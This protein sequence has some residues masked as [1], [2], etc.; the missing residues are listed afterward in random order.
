MELI[1]VKYMQLQ[2]VNHNPKKLDIWNFADPYSPQYWLNVWWEKPMFVI[3]ADK[4]I[5]C[6]LC[7]RNCPTGAITGVKTNPYV[8]DQSKCIRCGVCISKCKFQAIEKVYD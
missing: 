6:S 8:L 1:N 4:C 2:N 3:N 7:A 5:G